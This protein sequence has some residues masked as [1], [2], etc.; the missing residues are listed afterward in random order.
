M[1]CSAR[2]RVRVRAS[3]ESKE[4]WVA[5]TLVA[6]NISSARPLRCHR[7]GHRTDE[8]QI[9]S[10]GQGLVPIGPRVGDVPAAV[11]RRARL[12]EPWR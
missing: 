3:L 10:R 8:V 2:A 7:A 5:R 9:V 1:I 12:N 11:L 6:A 4:W